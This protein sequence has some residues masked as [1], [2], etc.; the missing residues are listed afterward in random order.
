MI[1]QWKIRVI[2]VR[3][4]SWPA[5]ST[6]SVPLGLMSQCVI[7]AHPVLPSVSKALVCPLSLSQ[8]LL[9]T[10]PSFSQAAF[11]LSHWAFLSPTLHSPHDQCL[12]TP[13]HCG[14]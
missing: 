4:I 3:N 5:L 8:S 6:H 2:G 11:D 13:D 1:K 7:P 14:T 10:L 12:T 9:R